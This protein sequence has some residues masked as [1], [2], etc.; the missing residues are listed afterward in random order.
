MSL[1]RNYF[2]FPEEYPLEV[3]SDQGWMMI[4]HLCLCLSEHILIL[5]L[6]R[7]SVLLDV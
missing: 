6:R 4:N 2:L 3:S 5:L 1:L 7:K